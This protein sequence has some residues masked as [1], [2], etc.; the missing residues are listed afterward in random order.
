M[1]RESKVILEAKGLD[2]KWI[3]IGVAYILTL[4]FF[5]GIFLGILGMISLG[6]ILLIGALAY[7]LGGVIIGKQSPTKIVVEPALS[8]L[9]VVGFSTVL[10]IIFK[11]TSEPMSNAFIITLI[12]LTFFLAIVGEYVGKKW[13]GAIKTAP[14]GFG[15]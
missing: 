5:G 6:S 3:G 13:Q 10:G 1:R 7:F 14:H 4:Q 12:M 8:A 2:F 11:I 9:F 15:K